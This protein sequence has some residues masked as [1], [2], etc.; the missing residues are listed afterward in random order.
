MADV[1]VKF[2]S[3]QCQTPGCEHENVIMHIPLEFNGPFYKV[4]SYRCVGCG[5]EPASK[6]MW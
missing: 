3:L 1:R 5:N 4:D 2:V 6:G